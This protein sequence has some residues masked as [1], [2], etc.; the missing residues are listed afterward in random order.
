MHRSAESYHRGMPVSVALQTVRPRTLAA[1][2]RDVA[3]GGVSSAWGPALDSVWRLI[4]NEPGL[5]TG[6]HNVF[7]YYHPTGPGAPLVCYF[8]V[9]V[10][11]AFD[12]AGEVAVV[13]TPEGE[14]AVAVHRGPYDRLNEAHGAIR[15]WMVAQHRSSAGYSWEIYGDPTPDPGDTETTVMYLLSPLRLSTQTGRPDGRVI[16]LR[17]DAEER[18]GSTEQDGG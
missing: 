1:V 3:A 16:L 15:E 11:S 6:G 13:E 4:R 10:S 7:L 17:K 14:A 9:E 8:G 12:A 2:R 18:P 5:W